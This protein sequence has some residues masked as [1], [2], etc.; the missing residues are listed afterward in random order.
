MNLSTDSGTTPVVC[1]LGMHRSGTSCLAGSLQQAGL[2]LGKYHSW[3][4]FNQKG[5]RENQDIVDFNE[6]LLAA[7][8][9]S[10]DRPPARLRYRTADVEAARA[11][12]QRYSGQQ[13]WGFKDPRTLLTLAL[14]R[15]AAVELR[16][17]GIFRHPRAVAESLRRRSGGK[18]A[19]AAT[20][21]LWGHY[22]QAL[23]DAWRRERFPLLCFDWEEQ[24][25]LEGLARVANRLGLADGSAAATF[26]SRG[27]LHYQGQ[28]W[29]EIPLRIKR[30]YEKLAA[31]SEA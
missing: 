13:P 14:W 8:R 24:R 25:L 31:A 22:N 17:V 15:E 16:C 3:N 20:L 30:L 11:L 27:L 9:A 18:M 1:I 10:W 4:R 2:H 29:E 28:R 5:S 21:R 6:A 19:A 12:I 26:Y 7:N 23:Y